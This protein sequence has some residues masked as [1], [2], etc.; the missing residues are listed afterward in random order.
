MK[1]L[2]T[3]SRGFVGK[4][5]LREIDPKH[6]VQECDYS[7]GQDITASDFVVEPGTDLV[8]HLASI[9]N[10]RSVHLKNLLYFVNVRGTLN[11]LEAAIAAK[12]PRFIFFS[13]AGVYDCVSLYAASKLSGEAYCRAVADRIQTKIVRPFNVYGPG[14]HWSTG[15]LIP[16]ILYSLFNKASIIING[17]GQ[18]TRDFIYVRDVAKFIAR[19]VEEDYLPIAEPIDLGTTRSISVVNII[20]LL[21]SIYSEETRDNRQLPRL[22]SVN[23]FPEPRFSQAADSM[24]LKELL[25]TPV[26]LESGLRETVAF[27]RDHVWRGRIPPS[28]NGHN[29]ESVGVSGTFSPA[30]T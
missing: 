3:G 9:L 10:T 30:H 2:I 6:T 27:W 19:E 11:L 28:S 14:Q 24:Y 1:I 25:P 13:S 12:V 5:I 26:S 4:H 15:A 16:T 7:L 23:S 18:Q 20:D 21:Q 22:S 29:K 8:I 17:D